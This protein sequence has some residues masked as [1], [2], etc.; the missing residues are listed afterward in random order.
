MIRLSKLTDKDILKLAEKSGCDWDGDTLT[1]G[2][3][4]Y[5]VDSSRGIVK[6]DQKND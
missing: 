3:Y 6:E 1:I 2:E 5:Y 4:T